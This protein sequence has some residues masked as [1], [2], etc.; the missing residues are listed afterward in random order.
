MS[1]EHEILLHTVF[2]TRH[3]FKCFS[4]GRTRIPS[5]E[6]ATEI[7][8]VGWNVRP[9]LSA[10]LV[11]LVCSLLPMLWATSLPAANKPNFVYILA[12]D[13]GYGDVNLEIEKL[14]ALNNP[15][16]KTPNLARLAKGG[17]VMTHHYAA[18]PVCSPSR[19]GLLTGR[20]PTRCNIHLWISDVRDNDKVFLHGEEVTIAEV[21]KAADYATAIFGKWH[22]NG[23]DWEDRKNWTGWTGSFP[24]QQGFDDGMVTKENPHES[25]A[26]KTNTQ[27]NPGDF[28]SI[29]GTPL[30]TMT[31][32]TSQ[33]ITDAAIDWL[34]TQRDA[35]QP[36]FLYL[37]YDAVHIRVECPSEYQAMYNTGNPNKDIY[38]GNV[39]HLD[40]QI[41]RLLDTLRTMGLEENTVVFFSSDHGPEILNFAKKNGGQSYS[42]TSSRNYGT[43]FPLHGQKRQLFEGSIRVPGIIRY[44]A[45][46]KH[47]ISHLPNS[48]LDVLPTVCELAGVP[49]PEG[50]ALDGT[51]LAAYL[52]RDEP[53][54]REKPLYWQFER[55]ENWTVTG[56]DYNRRYNGMLRRHDTPLPQVVVRQGNHVLRGMLPFV[57]RSEYAKT[58]RFR[59]PKD[60]V[61]YDVVN[62]P[63][64]HNELSKKLPKKF[65]ELLQ[66]LKAMHLEVNLDRMATER[67]SR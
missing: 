17:V 1:T 60:F 6:V 49:L 4:G 12:D 30:G 21:L 40:A 52:L 55:Q 63:E 42:G 27:D 51:S 48:T 56:R 67:S 31:G 44:P 11:R 64:E 50:R 36:F 58:K 59:L 57:S 28:F 16:L 2:S 13:L 33:I 38:Y 23:A 54:R 26:L 25:R 43:S 46:M 15:H 8:S 24:G 29:D 34:R 62:D 19:A 66:Q 41:G 22:L 39:T 5:S 14:G 7:M 45:G 47:R 37:P 3:R 53:V 9:F 65:D 32:W 20:T 61:M 10:L 18:A 35:E